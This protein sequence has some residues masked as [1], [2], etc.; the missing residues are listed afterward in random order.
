VG[1]HVSLQP[2]V[3]LL[4]VLL[5]L[6]SFQTCIFQQKAE[7]WTFFCLE[8]TDDIPV[9]RFWVLVMRPDIVTCDGVR[10]K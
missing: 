4:H 6:L 8:E 5:L 7:S 10:R 3:A 2:T 9:T 1:L